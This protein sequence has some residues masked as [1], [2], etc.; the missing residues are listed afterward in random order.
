[1]PNGPRLEARAGTSA[2]V[3]KK[4]LLHDLWNLV[5]LFV[6]IL[7]KLVDFLM[8]YAPVSRQLRQEGGVRYCERLC[9][10]C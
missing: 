8:L 9:N 2:G 5:Y 3:A 1:M 7:T 10:V 4:T 6:N